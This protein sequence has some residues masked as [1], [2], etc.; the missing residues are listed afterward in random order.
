L[1]IE[2]RIKA[3]TDSSGSCWLWL[4][5]TNRDG[6]GR[7]GFEKSTYLVHRA[8]YTALVGEIPAGWD[9]D[10]LCKVRNCVNPAHLEAVT[11]HENMLRADIRR[12]KTHCDKGHELTPENT[13][14]WTG[15]KW[16]GRRCRT[17]KRAYD[18]ARS[19]GPFP[20]VTS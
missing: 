1:K 20:G 4:G 18:R 12:R 10:H 5:C 17:C 3:K 11:H 6:Y 15:R 13:Y 16:A 2:E 14:E 9:I 8:M 7:V 19:A